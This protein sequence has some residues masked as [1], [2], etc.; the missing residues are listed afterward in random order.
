M[1]ETEHSFFSV[2]KENRE[3]AFIALQENKIPFDPLYGADIKIEITF[4]SKMNIGEPAFNEN[5]KFISDCYK[6]F[7]YYHSVVDFN[8][9]DCVIKTGVSGHYVDKIYNKYLKK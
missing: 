1:K 9:T 8:K 4:R 6:V 5:E 3:K 2:S 7:R